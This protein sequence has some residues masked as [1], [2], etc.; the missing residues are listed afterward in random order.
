MIKRTVATNHDMKILIPAACSV[1][2]LNVST[3][4]RLSNCCWNL[5]AQ[6]L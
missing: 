2:W 3:A 1:I 5:C 4:A 6:N